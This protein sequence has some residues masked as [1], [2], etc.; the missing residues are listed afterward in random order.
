MVACSLHQ[1]RAAA[2]ES[3]VTIQR[4]I[5]NPTNGGSVKTK[6]AAANT[7]RVARLADLKRSDP[8][9]FNALLADPESQKLY[10]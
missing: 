4:G 2:I 10:S 7:K 3:I 9:Q 1:V 8:A 6:V 5:M